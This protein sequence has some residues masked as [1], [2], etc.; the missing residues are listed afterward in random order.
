MWTVLI[1]FFHII[2]ISFRALCPAVN[3]SMYSHMGDAVCHVMQL[4]IYSCSHQI[5]AQGVH[6]LKDQTNA[7]L[8]L[9]SLGYMKGVSVQPVPAL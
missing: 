4:F 6:F 7:C 9:L 1:S 3:K 2:T 5:A 8:R